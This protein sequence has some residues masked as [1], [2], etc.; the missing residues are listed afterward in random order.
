VDLQ[1]NVRLAFRELLKTPG[2]AAAALLTLA[3]AIAANTA[4]FSAVYAVLLRPLP[5]REPENLVIGW[6]ADRARDVAVIEVT[7][8]QFRD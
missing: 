2:Y 6:K 4:I 1:R 8:N 3:L 5:I 7:Y